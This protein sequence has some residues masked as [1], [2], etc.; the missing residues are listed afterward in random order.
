MSKMQVS[1]IKGRGLGDYSKSMN[2]GITGMIVVI[3][4]FLLG[5]AV[6]IDNLGPFGI[7]YFA[8]MCRHKSYKVPVFFSIAIGIMLSHNGHSSLKYILTLMV[9]YL[10]SSKIIKENIS[11]IKIACIGAFVS[12]LVSIVYSFATGVYMYDVL[13]SVFE[14]SSI[15]ALIYIYSFGLP[16][17]LKSSTRRNITSEEV[18]ALTIILGFCISGINDVSVFDITLKNVLAMLFIMIFAFKGGPAIGAASGI[19]IGLIISMNTTASPLYIGIYGFSGLLGG[20]FSKINK[21]LSFIGFTMGYMVIMIYTQGNT[22]IMFY[23]K[24]AL[25]AGAIFLLMPKEHLSYLDRFISITKGGE[26][27]ANS[28]IK[29]VKEVMSGRLVDIESTYCEIATTFEKVREKEKILDQRDMAGV[30]DMICNDVC[31]GCTMRRSCWDMKFNNT[32]NT[33]M[34]IMNTLEEDGRVHSSNAPREFLRY[35]IKTDMIIKS[36]N[37]YFDLFILDYKWNKKICETRRLISTQIKG[38]ARCIKDVSSELNEEMTF[39]TEIEHNIL[40]ELEKQNI[41]VDN[42]SYLNTKRK[43]FEINI[44]KSPCYSADLCEKKVIPIISKV[45]DKK[46]TSQKLG[47][48]SVGDKCSIRLVQAQAFKARTEVASLSK[49]G[50][51]ISGDSYTYMDI[52]DGKYMAALSDG[53]GK[54]KKAYEQS[55]VTIALLEKMMESRIDEEISVNTINSML[56]LKSSEEIFSTLDLSIIDLKNGELEIIKMGACP[57]YVKR[58]KGGIEVVSCASLPIGILSDVKV[59]KEVR[60]IKEGDYII[61]VSDGIVDAGKNKNLGEGWLFNIIENT[62]NSNPSEFAKLIL[63][64]AMQVIEN[65]MEDDMTV[66]VTKIWKNS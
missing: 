24:D 55:S 52:S 21:Y 47:C 27:S 14:A 18:V 9:L 48:K 32:Y 10:I 31:S 57:T 22:Q 19:T 63:E 37:H 29:R 28:Y 13:V 6:V 5:R 49:D 59:N 66:M 1:T 17:I 61:M 54:G 16:I 15:F 8:Y 12:A 60:H 33:F 30:V 34:Q 11:T 4:G 46:L 62:K 58:A 56:I 40:C 26:E 20:V 50:N 38:L 2:F 41:R 7:A 39:N 42:V 23:L 51:V 53:M 64:K 45:V 3:L 43:G 36:A 35:C 25:A 44:Q 65:K